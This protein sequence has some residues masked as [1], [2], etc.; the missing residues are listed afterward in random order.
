MFPSIWVRISWW[1]MPVFQWVDSGQLFSPIV[2]A[3]AINPRW[4]NGILSRGITLFPF[5]SC[6]KITKFFPGRFVVPR[7]P[8]HHCVT[9]SCQEEDIMNSA[10]L[11]KHRCPGPYVL[12]CSKWDIHTGLADTPQDL[13]ET[14]DLLEDRLDTLG[15]LK[16]NKF[17]VFMQW[18]QPTLY[19]T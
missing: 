18:L 6:N 16:W 1:E 14:C 4:Y 15:C 2:Q 10:N 5:L 7:Q 13:W 12:P 9:A 19:K 3:Q 11:L 17:P 8:L